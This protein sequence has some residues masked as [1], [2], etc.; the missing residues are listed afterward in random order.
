MKKMRVLVTGG[1]GYI[2]S[3]VANL[4]EN[5]GYDVVV[6]DNLIY[7]QKP[8]KINCKFYKEDICC[9]KSISKIFKSEKI[10]AVAHLA[11]LIEVGESVARPQEFYKTNLQGTLNL[12]DCMLENSVNKII[13]SSSCAI[14][15]EPETIPMDE[16][17]SKN[18]ISAYAKSKLAVEYILEDYAK[19]YGLNSITLRY[20]NV[21]GASPEIGLGENHIP[22]T[23]LIPRLIRAIKNGQTCQIFGSDYATPD[24]TCVRDYLHVKDVAKAH[25]P[26][27]EYLNSNGEPEALNLGTGKGFSVREIILALEQLMNLEAKISLQPRRNGDAPILVCDGKKAKQILGWEPTNSGLKDILQSAIEWELLKTA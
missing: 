24:G 18:P 20:F 9:K 8:P 5:R 25:L 6:V 19:A 10:D 27:L 1:A 15:G 14:Y 4:F 7:N 16:K 23:H 21:A 17:H 3:H 26:A 2:G 12:L 22:E 11:A 13:F